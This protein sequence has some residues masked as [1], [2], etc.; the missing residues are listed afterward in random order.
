MSFWNHWSR[1]PNWFPDTAH[2]QWQSYHFEGGQMS[3]TPHWWSSWG[4]QQWDGLALAD[5]S[6]VKSFWSILPPSPLLCSKM[7]PAMVREHRG[8][9]QGM[10]GWQRGWRSFSKAAHW[11]HP[12]LHIIAFNNNK[13][14]LWVTR[15]YM[16]ILVVLVPPPKP[17][18][19]SD[20]V[21]TCITLATL[22]PHVFPDL[23]L[24]LLYITWQLNCVTWLACTQFWNLTKMCCICERHDGQI[25]LPSV[26]K[27]VVVWP[28]AKPC[29]CG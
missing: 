19:W 12:Q 25:L 13:F 3:R 9:A 7:E 4:G 1:V 23:S 29:S 5:A 17:R 20:H 14:L 22:Q 21:P 27:K 15:F 28:L 8:V 26:T 11:L 2:Y 18:S 6:L 24:A 10:G 16:N